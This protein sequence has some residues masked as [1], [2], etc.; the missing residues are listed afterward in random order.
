MT[1]KKFDQILDNR[2]FR[3]A[4]KD[5]QSSYKKNKNKSIE[6]LQMTVKSKKEKQVIITNSERNG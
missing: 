5:R 2:R 3:S 1:R 4:E 6:N